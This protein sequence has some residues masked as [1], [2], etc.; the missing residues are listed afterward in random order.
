MIEDHPLRYPLVNEL[1]AR[2]FPSLEVPC[3]AVYVAVKEPLDAHNRDRGRDRAHLLALLDRHGA[4]H[5]QPGATHH[6]ARIG[7]HD[8]KWESHTEFVTYSAFSRGLSARPFDPH[9]AEVFPLDWL[10]QAPGRRIASVLVRVEDLPEDAEEVR[11]R[12]EDW[13]VPESVACS[14]VLDEA[15]IIAG[16]FQI[17]PAGHMRFAVFVRPGTGARRVGRIVQRLCE[18]ETY[19]AMSMLGLGR[20]RELNSHLNA[21]DPK[22][23]QMVSAMADKSQPAEETLHE[24]LEIAAGLESL[25]V[26]HSFRFGATGAYEALVNQRVQ[27][28]RETR[29]NGRQ[30]FAEFMMRRYDPAMRTVKSAERRLSEMA[31]RAERAGELL[32][33]RVDVERSAQNQK[34]LESMDRRADLA[35]RLQHTVEGLSVVAISYYAVNL[36]AYAA[37][38]VAEPLGLSKGMMTAVLTPAVILLVWLMIRRIRRAMH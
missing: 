5:P 24:L 10:A 4:A 31:E 11:A 9:G 3:Q 15:A 38:P 37:Y 7:K 1:H 34:L 32:Q 2:P 30:T 23:S 29:F 12:I 27:I 36:A 18:V 35:L 21:L 33:T 26:R 6:A 28:L 14:W 25:A 8:L 17:D 19:R 13:F 20:S 16:D 22:L